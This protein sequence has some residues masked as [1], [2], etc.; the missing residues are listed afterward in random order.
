MLPTITTKALR[1]ITDTKPRDHNIIF[2]DAPERKKLLLFQYINYALENGKAAI[3]ICSDETPNQIRG[4]MRPL[5]PVDEME[6]ARR[7]QIRNYDEWYIEDGRADAMRIIGKWKTAYEDNKGRGMGL[8]VTGET[9]C[10]FVNDMVREL[11]RYEYALHRF[12][13]FPFE[14]LCAYNIQTIVETGYT[15]VIMPL[16]RAH[17]KALFLA[18]GGSMV[19]EP[20]NI[21]DT[22][23]EKLLQ[24]EI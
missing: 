1:F 5:I 13:D 12:L 6:K 16:V 15:D 24:L 3:Y 17:G 19:L 7:L 11:M 20:E 10:F 23:I 9:S 18:H 14:A 8:R 4:A 21:E 22:D 2:Y